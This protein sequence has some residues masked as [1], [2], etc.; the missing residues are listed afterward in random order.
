M[1]KQKIDGVVEAVHYG[2]DG[3]IQWLRMFK[4]RGFV[5]SDSVIVKRQD[6]VQFLEDRKIIFSG[7]RIPLRGSEFETD[8][9]LRLKEVNNHKIVITESVSNTHDHLDGVP[10]L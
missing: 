1:A 5:F 9:Q 6:L 10:I 7:R 4:K 3:N 8:K 2:N